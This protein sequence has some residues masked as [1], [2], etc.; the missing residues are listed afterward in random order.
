[1]HAA[2]QDCMSDGP[3]VNFGWIE[4][5]PVLV[6]KHGLLSAQL[7]P[8]RQSQSMLSAYRQG[9]GSLSVRLQ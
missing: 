4:M 9:W 5:R 1:M 6:L 7:A 3:D 8:Q 2:V